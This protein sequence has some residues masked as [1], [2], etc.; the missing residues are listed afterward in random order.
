MKR[1]ETR[2]RRP[3][4]VGVAVAAPEIITSVIGNGLISSG[5]IGSLGQ[6]GQITLTIQ[7]N[8]VVERMTI[9]LNGM[10]RVSHC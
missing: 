4:Q 2:S 1:L 9:L 6:A 3:L 5:E 7:K 8:L 10:V